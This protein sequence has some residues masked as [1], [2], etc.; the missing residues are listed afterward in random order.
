[1]LTYRVVREVTKNNQTGRTFETFYVEQRKR[2][3]WWSYWKPL[4]ENALGGC[5]FNKEFE[6]LEEAKA[7]A[8]RLNANID[9]YS[10]E[11]FVVD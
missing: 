9:L 4:Q 5:F 11:R 7:T 1:M 3:L 6:T 10:S 2:F 8:A